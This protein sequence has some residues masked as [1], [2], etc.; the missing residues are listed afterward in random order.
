MPA[1]PGLFS[2]GW[3]H[4]ILGKGL[5]KRREVRSPTQTACSGVC[6]SADQ[7]K[8]YS[9][10]TCAGHH[11]RNRGWSLS[12][13]DTTSSHC[14][15]CSPNTHNW[16]EALLEMKALLWARIPFFLALC[17]ISQLLISP[18]HHSPNPHKTGPICQTQN[19][20]SLDDKT[21]QKIKGFLEASPISA[22]ASFFL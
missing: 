10:H 2:Q 16:R 22:S 12:R 5:G 19:Q 11:T 8:D 9:K 18:F 3:K 13:T 21:K 6:F 14:T 1:S 17:S 15:H 4:L 7:K 20:R